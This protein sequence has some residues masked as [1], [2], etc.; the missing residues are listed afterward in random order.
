MG[1]YICIHIYTHIYIRMLILKLIHFVCY[2]MSF[3]LCAGGLLEWW[4]DLEKEYVQI[5]STL[6]SGI[7][8]QESAHY[9]EAMSALQVHTHVYI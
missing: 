2:V 8:G 1:A 6:A 3:V 9:S 7:A 4:E 5:H